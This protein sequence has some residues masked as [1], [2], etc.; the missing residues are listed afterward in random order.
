MKNMSS[1]EARDTWKIHDRRIRVLCTEGCVEGAI[2]IGRNWSIPI[3]ATKPTDAREASRKNY[4]GLEFDFSSIDSLKNT[5]D[6]HRPF[7]KGLAHSLQ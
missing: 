2:K 7:S 1:K 5:I 3:D 6:A 4:I